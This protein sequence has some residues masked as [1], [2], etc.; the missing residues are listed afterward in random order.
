MKV[1]MQRS[2]KDVLAGLTFVG[3]G[4][5]FAI[6]SLAYEIGD[7]VR[8]GPGFFPLTVGVLLAVLGV[9][10]AVTRSSEPDDV[11][12]T[13]PPWRAAGLILAAIVVFGLTVRGLGL[14]PSIFVTSLLA[15]LASRETRIPLAV[16]LAVGLTLLCIAIFVFALSL[17]L[18]LVGPWIPV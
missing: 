9:S 10:I 8:M 13:A 17:R 14:V 2:A 4:L 3:F 18:P 7:P 5:A 6:G 12:M 11:P 16:L 15:S 1:P